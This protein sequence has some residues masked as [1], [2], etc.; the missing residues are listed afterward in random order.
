[1]LPE[2]FRSSDQ[3]PNIKSQCV[4]LASTSHYKISF[5]K[6]LITIKVHSSKTKNSNFPTR[7]YNQSLFDISQKQYFLLMSLFFLFILSPSWI[8]IPKIAVICINPYVKDFG[9]HHR[10]T[11]FFYNYLIET[12]QKIVRSPGDLRKLAVSQNSS[13]KPSTK[14]GTQ[15]SHRSKIIISR[16]WNG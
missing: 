12:N 11:H 7:F 9:F 15:N 2:S 1:M 16:K 13:E 8:T 14:N 10:F 4:M 5:T 6:N 3:N